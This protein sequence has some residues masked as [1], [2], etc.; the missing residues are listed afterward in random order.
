MRKYAECKSAP[1]L[2]LG[3]L[4]V[5]WQCKKIGALFVERKTKVS[6]K[7]FAPLS[8]A[9][10]GVVPQL[11]TA[12]KTDA[13]DNR[14]LV[15]SGDFVINSRS[16]RKGSCG[17]SD[18]DGSV[19]LINIVLTP[20]D[21]LNSKYVHYLLRSQP[22]SEEYYR[23]GRGIVADLWTTR[24]SEMKSIMLPVPPRD[25]Q[26]QIVRFLDWKVSEINK[27]I[28][29]RRKEIKEL[30]ALKR[31]VIN[32][33]VTQGLNPNISI[34]YSGEQWLGN[35]P[36][37]WE[38]S[39]LKRVTKVRNEKG[40]FNPKVGDSYIGLEN[41]VSC[42]NILKT[43][44]SEYELSVQSLCYKGDL[45]FCKLRPY[46]AK[47]I[48]VPYDSFC[49]GELLIL[50]SFDGNMRFLRY[51]LLHERFIE[52]VNSSTYGAKMPR[53]NADFILNLQIP[54]PSIEEQNIIADYLDTKCQKITQTVEYINSLISVLEEYK[55]SLVADVVTGKIDVRGIKVPDYEFVAESADSATDDNEEAEAVEKN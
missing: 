51:V 47:V 44:S 9:K 5:H 48:I 37:H 24:Y 4:P 6:D 43:T 31:S 16:D 35:I 3:K 11:E 33:T 53:A 13:G 49:T 2:C 20:R 26:E 52:T 7:D 22:F 45:A 8:V 41:I 39:K 17:V 27:L 54:M 32:Y 30:E 10:I 36:N 23:N 14:K 55:I 46:L 40:I 21:E 18:L 15:C 50:A 28:N 19:S 12:V 34:K 38:I 29:I 1:A 42:S 25:E